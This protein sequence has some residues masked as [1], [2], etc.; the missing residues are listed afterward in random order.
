MRSRVLPGSSVPVAAWAT[1]GAS[2]GNIRQIEAGVLSVGGYAE[3]AGH[4]M[5]PVVILLHGWPYDIHSHVDVA[6]HLAAAGYRVIV[7]HTRGHGIDAV[8]LRTRH[9]AMASNRQLRSTPLH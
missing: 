7:P 9:S 8:S 1:S 5:G 3:V 2:F 6:P 4:T